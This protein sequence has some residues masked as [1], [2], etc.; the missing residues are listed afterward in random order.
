MPLRLPVLAGFPAHRYTIQIGPTTVVVR[1]VWR[2]RPAAWYLDIYDQDGVTPLSLGR[3]LSPGWG[4]LLGLGARLPDLGGVIIVGGADP[5]RQA[6]V[7][8]GLPVE[9]LWFSDAEI[10]ALAPAVD[11]DAAVVVELV[12]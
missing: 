4:P 3:R 9:V 6:D 2:D 5:Y 8:P 11:P 12:P 10:A 1:L 7:G